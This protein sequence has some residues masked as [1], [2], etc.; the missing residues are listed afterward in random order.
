VQHVTVAVDGSECGAFG[1]AA[2]FPP[3]VPSPDWAGLVVG[4]GWEDGLPTA[5]FAVPDGATSPP[6]GSRVTSLTSRGA[7]SERRAAMLN[8]IRM[9]VLSR[10]P[11]RVG[12]QVST[13]RCR[14]RIVSAG[15][16]PRPIVTFSRLRF[17][18][19]ARTILRAS[20]VMP[21][22]MVSFACLQPSKTPVSRRPIVAGACAGRSGCGCASHVTKATSNPVTQYGDGRF[23]WRRTPA[24]ALSLGRTH[25]G[26]WAPPPCRATPRRRLRSAEADAVARPT[27]RTLRTSGL[28]CK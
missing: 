20:L 22:G 8:P 21:W 17:R 19:Y 6:L 7:S 11:S 16:E 14:S 15:V 12:R 5:G 18:S 9:M 2:G 24:R 1:D 4:A 26:R 10:I 28:A 3:F 27:H 25:G 13:M 23:R